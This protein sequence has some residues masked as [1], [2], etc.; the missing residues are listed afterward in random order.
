MN[1][2]GK[3][4]YY[5]IAAFNLV[6]MLILAIPKI[7]EKLRNFDSND[8]KEKLDTENL[9]GNISK[10]RDDVG[11]DEKISQI[12]NTE[13]LTK[14]IKKTVNREVEDDSDSDVVMIAGAFTSEEKERTILTLQLLSAAFVVISILSIFHFVDSIIYIPI[15]IVLVGYIIYLLYTKV[16]LMYRKD[17]PA[18]RDFFLM[19]IAVGIILV[20]LNTNP[21]FVM[22]FS[23]TLLPS[24]SVLI[25]AV[26]AVVAVFLIYRIRYYRNFTYGT[27][28]E[29]G[30]N[31][32]YVKV[33][34]DI[35]S[36]VKPDI[37]IVENRVGAYE[38]E[39]VKL[40][41]E[42]KIMSMGGNKPVKIIERANN[43]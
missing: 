18:Y 22:A 40:Q 8:F 20:L 31:T 15:G 38:G 5:I 28:I 27:V 43:I 17:F 21:N 19:Y 13:N 34:Y 33:E 35:R 29:E 10:L 2:F 11:L 16:N 4:G 26:V 3:L 42:E 24:L 9:K 23:F 12:S 1:I 37:Y 32:A 25:F 39:V 14:T 6:G 7:P 30:K 41:L 36:N